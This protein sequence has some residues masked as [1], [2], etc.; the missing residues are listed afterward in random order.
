[1]LRSSYYQDKTFWMAEEWITWYWA[2]SLDE[3]QVVTKSYD[4][5][6]SSSLCPSARQM[7]IL[8]MVYRLFPS[9]TS[10]ADIMNQP[11]TIW[12]KN[13]MLMAGYTSC[14]GDWV[15]G[16]ITWDVCQSVRIIPLTRVFALGKRK[17]DYNKYMQLYYTYIFSKYAFKVSHIQANIGKGTDE[18]FSPGNTWSKE[19]PLVLEATNLPE[20]SG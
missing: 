18:H 17:K 8:W 12:R 13:G 19:I 7:S 6:I 20:K 11:L 2:T 15:T 5:L 9:Y 3:C 14:E 10:I 4:A 16:I 1:M